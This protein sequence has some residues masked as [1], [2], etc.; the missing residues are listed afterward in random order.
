[1]ATARASFASAARLTAY[2]AKRYPGRTGILSLLSRKGEAELCAITRHTIEESGCRS[3]LD[4]GCGDGLMLANAM[5]HALDRVVL[6]DLVEANVEQAAAA[7]APVATIVEGKVDDVRAVSSAESFDLVLMLG[8]FEY[9]PDWRQTL[10]RLAS[11]VTGW[12]L[13]NLPR[14]DRFWHRLRR[15]RLSL[16]GLELFPATRQQLQGVFEG[17]PGTATVFP[18]RL[19]WFCLYKAP[20][21]R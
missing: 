10:H 6:V 13:V 18:G 19:S 16:L 11:T 4:L 5:T 21:L 9:L 1:M 20:G 17:L 14:S 2:F 7:L 8:V 15:W 3:I 12:M